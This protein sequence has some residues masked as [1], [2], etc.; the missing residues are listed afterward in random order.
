MKG[1]RKGGG[2]SGKKVETTS[3]IHKHVDDGS[4]NSNWNPRE[5]VR[6]VGGKYSSEKGREN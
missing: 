4:G 5:S 6:P 2:E 3:K 1:I